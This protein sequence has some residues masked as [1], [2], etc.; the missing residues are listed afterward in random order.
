MKNLILK[1]AK[2]LIR[3]RIAMAGDWKFY[4]TPGA[5]L[6]GP[7]NGVSYWGDYHTL[8]QVCQ[9]FGLQFVRYD[10]HA[11]SGLVMAAAR[12]IGERHDRL[13]AAINR[14]TQ[15]GTTHYADNSVEATEVNRFGVK[16]T[17]MLV[18]P[19]GDRCF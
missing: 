4:A 11:E 1:A 7:H 10:D 17:V 18:A 8:E 14:W 6:C 15:V 9:K 2:E 5:C 19:H 3:C 16:R 12:K 13:C